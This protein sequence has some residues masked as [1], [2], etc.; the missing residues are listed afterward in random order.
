MILKELKSPIRIYWDLSPAPHREYPDHLKICRELVDNKVLSLDL[1]EPGPSLSHACFAILE[2]LKNTPLSLSLTVSQAALNGPAIE[3]LQG[4]SVR[5]LFIAT[6]SG[7]ELESIREIQK[8]TA[9][10]PP[11]GL[12]FSV[13]RNNY[14]ELPEVLSFCIKSGISPLVFPMQRLGDE[15]DCFF[16][17]KQERQGLAERLHDLPVP[18]GMKLIIHDPF[19]WRVFYPATAFPGGGCQAANTML[20]ISPE[21]D[22]YPCPSLPIKIGN[23]IKESLKEVILSDRKK[24]LRESVVAFPQGCRDCSES[25]QCAGG[26][27][28]RAY[29]ITSSLSEP[30]PA[31]R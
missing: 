27:R 1:R 26:C 6:A 14:H 21:A 16:I 28:G 19:L 22:V 20:F 7:L 11:V 17:N 23:L 15:K 10:R 13:S 5:A 30:D 18:P 29:M 25:A 3:L 8:R 12:S 2:N 31:C 9:G 24:E 4:L